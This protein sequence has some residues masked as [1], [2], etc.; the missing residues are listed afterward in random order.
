MKRN[1]KKRPV[2]HDGN[3]VLFPD[4]ESRLLNKAM[5]LVEEK[6]YRE[7]RPLFGKLLRLNVHDIKGLYGWAICSV[8]LG[9][10]SQAE[11]AVRQLLTD[12]APYY[13]DVFRLYLTILIEKKDYHMA[14]HEIRKVNKEKDM[15]ADLQEFLRQMEKLCEI[16][17]NEKQNRGGAP[18]RTAKSPD[19]ASLDLSGFKQADQK[20]RLLLARNLANQLNRKSLPKVEQFLLDKNQNSEIKTVLM[21]AVK[22]SGLVDGVNVWKF[23][24]VYHATFNENFLNKTF[25]G[26]VEK[27][28]RDVLD[29]ENPTLADLAA[30]VCRFFTMQ[31]YPRPFEPPS[32]NVWA[33]VFTVQAAEAGNMQKDIA[34]MLRLFDVQES[35]FQKACSMISDVERFGINE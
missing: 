23:G 33:A 12:G 14:L 10:Y 21:C 27:H 9:E 32:I 29:S 28:I 26:R 2:R 4:L 18:G 15:S 20:T 19:D 24:K 35:D 16:R 6:K 17:L 8:E 34:G 5:T 25:A 1:R 22:E 3:L 11:G 7:A 30:D 13:Y 31:I